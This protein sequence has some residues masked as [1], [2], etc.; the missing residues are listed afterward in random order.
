L[1]GGACGAELTPD[2]A[3]FEASIVTGISDKM[4][5]ELRIL[6]ACV[7]LLRFPEGSPQTLV[8]LARIGNFEIRMFR[9]HQ[10]ISGAV[11]LFWLELFDHRS[12]SSVDSCSCNEIE[13]AAV[14]F[15]N[16]VSQVADL[17]DA[18]GSGGTET[19]S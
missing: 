9:G 15:E 4:I 1:P 2:P 17:N 7:K 16:F 6:R 11:P 8:S 3:A 10:V 19:H 5:S 12:S 13:D 18:F 14:V